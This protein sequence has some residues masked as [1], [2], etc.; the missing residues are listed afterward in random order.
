MKILTNL[1]I[2]Y[3][4]F[5]TLKDAGK[6]FSY[7]YSTFSQQIATASLQNVFTNI[8]NQQGIPGILYCWPL[9]PVL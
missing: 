9:G 6:F 3:F 2:S 8:T 1:L 4:F 5:H 7:K